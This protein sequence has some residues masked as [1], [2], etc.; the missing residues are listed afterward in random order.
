MNNNY[1]VHELL[2]ALAGL[3]NR[4]LR[5]LAAV[6]AKRDAGKAFSKAI[7]EIVLLREAERR[8]RK[9]RSKQLQEVQSGRE[10]LAG[11]TIVSPNEVRYYPKE[12]IKTRFYEVLNNRDVLPSTK[13]VIEVL[14]ESFPFKFEYSEFRR[15]GRRDLIG[16]CWGYLEEMPSAP[17]RKLLETFFRRTYKGSIEGEGYQELFKI[18]SQK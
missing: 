3:S 10:G 9:A 18:L 17:Q 11:T 1:V 15:R 7:E 5:Q 4:Q 16:K 13:D 12:V 8:T 6:F 14:R 2:A